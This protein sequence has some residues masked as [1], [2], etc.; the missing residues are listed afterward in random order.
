MTAD[1]PPGDS[2]GA[3]HADPEFDLRRTVA[4]VSGG[5]RGFGRL[6]AARLAG[7]GASVG[8][9]ARSAAELALTVREIEQSGGTAA[10]AVCDVADR[11]AAAAAV[12]ELSGRLGAANLL[13]NNA[14]VAGPA[15]RLWDVT[16][17][18]WWRTFEIN[19]G[20]AVTLSQL[21]LPA[22]V[23]AGRGRIVNITSHAGVYRWPL[24]SAYAASK[25]ALVKLT[26]TLAAETRPYGVAVFSADPGLLPIGLGE[27]ATASRA[28]RRHP[29]AWSTA[30]S[31]T[32]CAP[33]AAPTRPAPR[34]WCWRSPAAAATACPGGT[35][36]LRTILM[37]CW[38]A[39]TASSA[40]TCTR[41][42]CAPSRASPGRRAAAA[43]RP[44][45]PCPA[46]SRRSCR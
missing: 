27:T 14:G 32:S 30:G 10:S 3:G 18:E 21:V 36:R 26:E 17:A 13:V 6:L 4:I 44:S 28:G 42:G 40:T 5:G 9:I 8:V 20:G 25:A 1:M 11:R 39:S 41:S 16:A 29:K 34:G 7:A 43:G 15:G 24:M 38:R 37:R 19:V 22:M 2:D 23:A 12:V 35:S 31:G 45:I 33:A 46:G